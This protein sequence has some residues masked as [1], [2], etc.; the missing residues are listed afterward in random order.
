MNNGQVH[1]LI[2]KQKGGLYATVT[3][4]EDPWE[5]RVELLFLQVLS[6][7]PTQAETERFV[8]H[9]E[10]GDDASERLHE[11]IWTLMTCS[12]FRFNH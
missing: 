12:E 1:S 2:T 7:R 8:A 5:K 4:S 3:D 9:L 6:R 11:A 10:S